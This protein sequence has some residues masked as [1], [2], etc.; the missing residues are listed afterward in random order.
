MLDEDQKRIIEPFKNGLKNMEK[1]G[2]AGKKGEA[3]KV[4][5]AHPGCDATDT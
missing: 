1:L 3:Y 5:C 4:K 2:L